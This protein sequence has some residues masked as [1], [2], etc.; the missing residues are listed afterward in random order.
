VSG[1][2]WLVAGATP[3]G[4][5]T[6]L[7]YVIDGGPFS[8]ALIGTATNTIYGWLFSWNTTSVPSG[9]TPGI[10][11]VFA[12]AYINSTAFDDS[13]AVTLTLNS[14]SSPGGPA[15]TGA[16]APTVLLSGKQLDFPDPSVFR[17]SD[18]TFYAYSTGTFAYSA[19]VASS[20]DGVT[21]TWVGDPFG[22]GGS[23]WANLFAHTWAPVVLERPN[24]PPSS[25]F[26]MYYTSRSDALNTQCIGRA[27]SS[28][29]TGPFFDEMTVPLVC[30]TSDVWSID[31]DPYVAADGSV[32]L[33]WSSGDASTVARIWS[34][35]L[36]SDG[37]SFASGTTA[38]N[39]VTYVPGTWE[40]PV[41]EAPA[42]MPDPAGGLFLFYAG[43]S[44]PS[45]GYATGVAHCSSPTSACTRSYTTPVLATR[46]TMAGPGGGTPFRDASGNWMFAFHAW[47]SPYIGY[48]DYGIG[49][50]SLRILP[51]TLVNGLPKIG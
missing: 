36:N 30:Q 18:G 11:N 34:R 4:S 28:S 35:R 44:W 31:P 21:W 40:N 37:L 19:Q 22:N 7:D 23:T 14:P 39:I 25:R 13:P 50:R 16:Y 17:A 6:R 2:T 1:T 26:V 48:D 5:V 33:V 41:V 46:S 15:P 29:P 38:T 51:I 9:I 42:F 27:T 24:N 3:A 20:P 10:Y 43:N 12:R 45:S 32:Y 47:E 8:K 49:K